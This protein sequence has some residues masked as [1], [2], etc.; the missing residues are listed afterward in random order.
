MR[1]EILAKIKLVVNA[2]SEETFFDF[3]IS[4]KTKDLAEK[5]PPKLLLR[6]S[7]RGAAN[8]YKNGHWYAP[9]GG[10]RCNDNQ[11]DSFVDNFKG[12]ILN[13]VKK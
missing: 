2:T 12:R 13:T 4:R 3:I 7:S 9:K 11:Y 1:A 8:G 6:I 10:F 5:D